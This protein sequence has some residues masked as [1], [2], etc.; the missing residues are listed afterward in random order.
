MTDDVGATGGGSDMAQAGSSPAPQTSIWEE[1]NQWGSGLPDWQRLILSHSVRDGRLTDDRVGE[2]YRLFLREKT[3]DK[4]DEELPTV[5]SSVTGRAPA[6]GTPLQLLGVKAL[7][8]VN[9]I[10]EAAHILFGPQLTII[11]GHNGAGKSGFARILSRACFS[12][13]NPEIIRNIYEDGAADSPATAQFIVNR[14][15]GL[16]EDIAFTI[17][18]EHHD[19][20]RVSVF[21]SSVARIHLAKE[22]ELGF[23]PAGFDVFDEAIRVVTLIGQK[24]DADVQQ[25]TRPNKFDQL[26]ADPGLVADHISGLTAQTDVAALQALATFGPEEQERLEEVAR[27]EKELLAKSPVETLK[28]L[29]AARTDIQALHA[30]IPILAGKLGADAAD[31]ARTLLADH[32]AALLEAVKAGSES[33]SHPGLHQTGS[34]QWDALVLASRTLGQ[35]EAEFYPIDGDPCLLCHRPLDTPSITLIRRMWAYLDHEARQNAMA[36]DARI[37]SLITELKALDCALLPMD[38]RIRSDLSK[39]DPALISAIDAMAAS[40]DKRRADLVDAL[41]TGVAEGLPTGGFAIADDALGAAL[42]KVDAQDAALRGGKFDDLLANLKREHIELRQRQVLSKNITDVLSFVDDLAW[43]DKASRARPNT[44]FV[45][46]RQKQ[47]FEKLIE[48][49]YK[50]RLKDECERLHCA[51]PYEFKARGS[52]GKT[53]RGLKAKGGHKP[54][55]IFSEGEQRALSLADFLT[56]VNLNPASAAIILDDPVTSLDHQRKIAIAKRL[57]E[58]AAVRQVIIFTHDLVFLTLLSD[59]A[60]TLGH[61]MRGHWID[62]HN[63]RPGHVIIDE[64]PANTKVYRKTTKAKE[65]L[66]RAKSA[67]GREKVDLVRSGAG[68]LRRTI[69]EV[70]I[71]HL[72]KDTVRRWNEQIRLGAIGKIAWSDAVADEIVTLQD[73]TSRLLEGH[74]NSDEFA[75]GMPDVDGLERLIGRVDAVIDQVKSERKSS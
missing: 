29:A 46:D 69:E 53:L 62:R 68:A 33:V 67:S 21:D 71:F 14:D 36:A 22:N 41:E 5:P 3:L 73:D 6:Q 17:G 45:T 32:K 26:F 61:A 25:K 51:L 12:R 2:S 34:R 15:N 42:V 24:L 1:L 54:D 35:A 70:V 8:N 64:I 39:F 11:Y 37:N 38:S 55:D 50:D 74:S 10:P 52:A 56:E 43:I 66:A 16:D 58:E 18:D 72:F 23:Q 59:H 47:M 7:T 57:V 19:L 44:R 49:S 30:K 4:G 40:L 31:R 13:S 75:G 65:F 27:Q 48:G 20:K 28:A 9:A 63:D 60:E